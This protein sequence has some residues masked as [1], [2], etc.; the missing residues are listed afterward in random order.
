MSALALPAT[1]TQA[2]ATVCL[3]ELS[4]ALGV[5]SGAV[6]VDGHALQQFDSAALA[7]LLAL[8][9][10]ALASGGDLQVSHLPQRLA[11]L[12]RLYGVL[13]LLGS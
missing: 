10:Q 5:Q 8:R 4:Q 6:Q 7:V 3:R 2:N 12:A 1:L 13:A 11:D 9:R